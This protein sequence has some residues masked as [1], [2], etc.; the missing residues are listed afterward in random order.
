MHDVTRMVWSEDDSFPRCVYLSIRPGIIT[1]PPVDLVHTQAPKATV[2]KDN[3]AP[4][5]M[6]CKR[7]T[8]T[9]EAGEERLEWLNAKCRAPNTKGR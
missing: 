5:T 7:C 4:Q 2:G 6:S 9:D 8:L 1:I 3:E